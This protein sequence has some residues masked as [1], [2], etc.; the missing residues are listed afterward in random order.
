MLTIIQYCDTIE[1]SVTFGGA[2]MGEKKIWTIKDSLCSL[3]LCLRDHKTF[4]FMFTICSLIS[5]G[6]YILSTIYS[7]T[8][9]IIILGILSS[10]VTSSAIFQ[11]S[12]YIKQKDYATTVILL[13]DKQEKL[14]GSNILTVEKNK[15]AVIKLLNI[16]TSAIF[17]YFLVNSDR[18]VFLKETSQIVSDGAKVSLE[19][20]SCTNQEPYNLSLANGNNLF[21]R[22][23]DDSRDIKTSKE[24][25]FFI[26]LTCFLALFKF[27]FEICKFKF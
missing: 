18:Q 17:V 13:K 9:N 22:I 27:F 7:N 12:L 10:L 20:D 19:K 1:K 3:A 11:I 5:L 8:I 14:L 25:V 2:F 23:I 4:Y 16:S 26:A 24:S 21:F 15:M 6:V